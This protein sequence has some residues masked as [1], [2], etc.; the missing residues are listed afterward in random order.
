MTCDLTIQYD[1]IVS[2]LIRQS[3][4]TT[5][6]ATHERVLFKRYTIEQSRRIVERLLV[7]SYFA[8]VELP[9]DDGSTRHIALPAAR[10]SASTQQVEI[11]PFVVSSSVR[12]ED[13]PWLVS[14][15]FAS[16]LR[17]A[18]HLSPDPPVTRMLL[19]FDERPVET[20]QTTASERLA[21]SMDSLTSLVTWLSSREQQRGFAEEVF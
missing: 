5:S 16:R 7:E 15:A 8:R 4:E 3:V 18:F 13:P 9:E 11:L 21:K 19:L 1:E 12:E 14:Q 20:E 10:W 2:R 6:I 17:T